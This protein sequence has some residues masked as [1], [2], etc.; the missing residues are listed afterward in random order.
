MAKLS[1][2]TPEFLKLVND[3]KFREE[4]KKQESLESIRNLFSENGINM[5]DEE[6]KEFVE[7]V[8]FASGEEVKSKF[9]DKI[10]GGRTISESVENFIQEHPFLTFFIA[11]KTISVPVK[12]AA[13]ISH[14]RNAEAE[15]RQAESLVVLEKYRRRHFGS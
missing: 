12:I 8:K 2:E 9:L 1:F 6:F 5:T 14:T 11:I 10:S 3:E 13:D 15:A 4:M 7:S